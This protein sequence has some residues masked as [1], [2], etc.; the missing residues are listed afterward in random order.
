MNYSFLFNL[1]LTLA[2]KKKKKHKYNMPQEKST[3]NSFYIVK[4]VS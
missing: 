4:K 3:S 1:K 2:C